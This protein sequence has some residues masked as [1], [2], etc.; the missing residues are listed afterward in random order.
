MIIYTGC[1][2][3]ALK[4]FVTKCVENEVL[5]KD[6]KEIYYYEPPKEGEDEV[7]DRSTNLIPTVTKE[8]GKYLIKI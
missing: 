5:L 7:C 8:C 1:G 6:K 4:V 2:K 3:N